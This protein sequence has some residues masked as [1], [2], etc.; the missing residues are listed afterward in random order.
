MRLSAIVL[1]IVLS[2]SGCHIAS[3]QPFSELTRAK[4]LIDDRLGPDHPSRGHLM[5][6]ASNLDQTVR[7]PGDA[8]IARA[9]LISS[10]CLGLLPEGHLGSETRETV[11]AAIISTP[12]R[13]AAFRQYVMLSSAMA[14][15]PRESE[16]QEQ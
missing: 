2:T 7:H 6:Y 15:T 13:A 11:D 14:L 9:M 4:Q 3:D 1:T 10:N 8:T 16:C 5:L 12:A